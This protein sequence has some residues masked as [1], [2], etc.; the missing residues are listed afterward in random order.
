[1]GKLILV[2]SDGNLKS[3]KCSTPWKVCSSCREIKKIHGDGTKFTNVFYWS[4]DG[5]GG[6]AMIYGEHKEP[7]AKLNL[8]ASHLTGMDIYGDAAIVALYVGIDLYDLYYLNDSQVEMILSLYDKGE[9]RH[10]NAKER[11]SANVTTK[12]GRIPKQ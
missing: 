11:E 1:M 3:I 7:T 5:F 8:F 9:W 12:I 2:N 10:E 4:D 6:L